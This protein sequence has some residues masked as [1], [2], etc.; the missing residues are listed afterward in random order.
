MTTLKLL[1]AT[2]SAKMAL[3]PYLIAPGE[4]RERFSRALERNIRLRI[5]DINNPL[6]LPYTTYVVLSATFVTELQALL[7]A[8]EDLVGIEDPEEW[9]RQNYY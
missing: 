5:E 9:L 1:S 4:A 8:V 2:L 6:F 3:P 7:E